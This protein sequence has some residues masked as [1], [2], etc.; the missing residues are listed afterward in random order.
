MRTEKYFNASF[1]R[2][3]LS[4]CSALNKIN[5]LDLCKIMVWTSGKSNIYRQFRFSS[6]YAYRTVFFLEYEFFSFHYFTNDFSNLFYLFDFGVRNFS[7]KP[8]SDEY[9]GNGWRDPLQTR[10]K[11]TKKIVFFDCIFVGVTIL[12]SLTVFLNL[13]AETLP[14]VSDAIPLLG[15]RRWLH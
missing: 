6:W 7:E 13:V 2:L 1:L 10:V 8:K 14:Q 11:R 9:C 5:S 12:L 15:S 3:M 4:S